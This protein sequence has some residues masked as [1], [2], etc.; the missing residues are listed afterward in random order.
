MRPLALLADPIFRAVE[1]E[2]YAYSRNLH[3]LETL[4]DRRSDLAV[5]RSPSEFR[6]R[7]DTGGAYSDPIWQYI[8]AQ[9]EL[10]EE[11]AR[12]RLR[13]RPIL[14]MLDHLGESRPELVRLDIVLTSPSARRWDVENRVKVLS[15]LL[16]R[17]KFWKDDSQIW[18]L[19]VRREKGHPEATLITIEPLNSPGFPESSRRGDRS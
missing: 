11:I 9:E 1:R 4:E 10:E 2:F 8:E 12:Y 7:V 6:E 13:V 17:M 14:H 5:L 3:H 16:T 19:R 15:D 18:D